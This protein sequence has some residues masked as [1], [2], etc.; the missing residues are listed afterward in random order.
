MA[1]ASLDTF[2]VDTTGLPTLDTKATIDD[3]IIEIKTQQATKNPDFNL[4]HSAY[5]KKGLRAYKLAIIFE[6]KSRNDGEFK[7]YVLDI[8][9]VQSRKNKGWFFN[10]ENKF[11]LS[12]ES[13]EIDN[14]YKL[15]DVFIKDNKPALEGEYVVVNKSS[16]NTLPI[17]SHNTDEIIEAVLED[18]NILNSLFE[19]G[20]EELVRYWSKVA[21]TKD[22]L[23]LISELFSTLKGNSEEDKLELLSLIKDLNL[24]KN[25]INI[26]S[27]RKENLI[28]FQRELNESSQWKETDWQVFFEHNNWIFGYGLNYRFF[29]VLQREAHV[30]NTNLTSNND[31]T[32]DFLV[33]D[34][35]FTAIVELKRPDTPLF[36]KDINR[37]GSWQLSKDLTFAVSQILEQKASWILKSESSQYDSSGQLITQKTF[38]PKT[39]LVIGHS[40]QFSGTDQ[41]SRIKA[42]TFELYRRNSKDIEILTY[43]E[44]L[45]RA[46]FIVNDSE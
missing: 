8:Y 2:S 37:A 9:D 28:T 11:T 46:T 42:K 21:S 6:I 13:G 24:N 25:D 15:L 41:N 18:D 33:G 26:I 27:G 16:L 14:L 39:I 35:N 45:D 32:T 34:N 29:K 17:I 38:D 10:I 7:H 22:S 4:I 40:E 36:E 3:V 23:L 5:I 19:K 1:N 31:S 43:N 12:N 30:S 20:G 44:L